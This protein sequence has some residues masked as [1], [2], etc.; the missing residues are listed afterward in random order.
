MRH[1][2]RSF[3]LGLLWAWLV[4]AVL[5]PAPAPVAAART[6]ETRIP[7]ATWEVPINDIAGLG[8][9]RTDLLVKAFSPSMDPVRY[10]DAAEAHGYKVVVY[11]T[12]T[13]TEATGSVYPGRVAKW[14]AKVVDHPALYGYMTVKEPSWHG[15]TVTE[16]RRLYDT[17]RALDPRRPIVALLGD[18][19]HFGTSAN[20]WATGIADILWVDWY[21]VTFSRGYIGTAATHFPKVRSAVQR[22]T[23]GTPI[24]LM[25]QGHSYRPGDRRSPTTAELRRQVRD[26]LTYLGADGIAIHTW[27]NQRYDRDLRRDPGLWGSF[28]TIVREVKSGTF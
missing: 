2:R 24:W 5:S 20:P 4:V 9:P 25:V 17:F 28:R 3:A 27:N 23:P 14:V 13:V 11:F 18:I 1:W 26:G 19:P 6:L 22:I 16:M 21:P 7:F 8:S 10:L 12:D 15:I